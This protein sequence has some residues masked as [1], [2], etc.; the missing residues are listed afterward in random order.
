MSIL[1][2]YVKH[3]TTGLNDWQIMLLIDM[4][5]KRLKRSAE[6]ETKQVR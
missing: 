2:E 5:K 4:L 3:L 6:N 1:F